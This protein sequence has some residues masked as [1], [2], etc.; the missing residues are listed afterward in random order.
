M[1]KY[2]ILQKLQCQL[3]HTIPFY[4]L[5]AFYTCILCMLYL[6]LS[7]KLKSRNFS[8]Q[9]Q[10]KEIL[11]P[12]FQKNLYCKKYS[13][14]HNDEDIFKIAREKPCQKVQYFKVDFHRRVLIL[15]CV[16]YM[17]VHVTRAN[18]EE[19]SY[20]LFRLNV[21]LSEVQL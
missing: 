19:T 15:T 9:G 16:Y 13:T 2:C 20:E 21:K 12:W 7:L 1:R 4:L 6:N 17:Q 18:E 5:T 3:Q 8:R 11:G 14:C 10:K